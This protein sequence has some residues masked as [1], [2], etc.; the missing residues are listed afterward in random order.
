MEI[1]SPIPTY[2]DHHDR[3]ETPKTSKTTALGS[4]YLVSSTWV[5]NIQYFVDLKIIASP[6]AI[7]VRTK[8]QPSEGT[9]R[10]P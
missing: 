9:F 4:F 7:F 6:R 1:K 5:Y 10:G 8:D 3:I 2:F